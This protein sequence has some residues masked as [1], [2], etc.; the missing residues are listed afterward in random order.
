M[1]DTSEKTYVKLTRGKRA[2]IDAEDLKKVAKHKW[3]A[4]LK[5]TDG[6]RFYAKSGELSLHRFVLKTIPKGCIVSFR[7]KNSLDC[8]KINLVICKKG[9]PLFKP[10]RINKSSLPDLSKYVGIRE[11]IRYAA[12]F[13]DGTGRKYFFGS[14]ATPSEAATVY[15]KNMTIMKNNFTEKIKLNPKHL[16]LKK[17]K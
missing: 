2:I 9:K 6:T 3:Y 4:S 5:R 8:R 15:N 16:L 10:S 17:G 13:I 14:Y 7:N 1:S 11:E 12:E